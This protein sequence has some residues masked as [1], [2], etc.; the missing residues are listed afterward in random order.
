MQR[1]GGEEENARPSW[2]IAW[3]WEAYTTRMQ[4]PI[5]SASYADTPVFV[6]GCTGRPGLLSFAVR[7]CR[8]ASPPISL[9]ECCRTKRA[10][11]ILLLLP[12]G[13]RKSGRRRLRSF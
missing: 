3:T 10:C 9:I 7:M 6:A 8:T 11:R 5:F 2:R 1:R 12:L 13:G 4:P